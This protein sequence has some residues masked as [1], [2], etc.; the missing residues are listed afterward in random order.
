M[1]NYLVYLR[2]FLEVFG[3]SRPFSLFFLSLLSVVLAFEILNYL[4]NRR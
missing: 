3:L 2:D 4:R 1:D